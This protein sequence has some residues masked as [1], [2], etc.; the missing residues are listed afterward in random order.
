[1]QRHVGVLARVLGGAADLDLRERDLVDSLAADVLVGQRGAAEMAVGE[2]LERVRLVRFPDVALEHRVVRVAAHVDA[3]GGEDVAVV[4]GVVA[5]FRRGRVLEPGLQAGHDRLERELVGDAG[6]AVRDRD[7]ARL[8]RRDREREADQAGADRVERIGLDVERGE[9]GGGDPRDPGVERVERRHRLV[10]LD[11][12]L[13]RHGVARFERRRWR[14]RRRALA[15]GRT[16]APERSLELAPHRREAVAVVEGEQPVDVDLAQRERVELGPAEDVAREVAVGDDGDEPAPLRQPVD[17]L[18]QVLA[19]DALDL[20]RRRDHAFERAVLGD[21]LRRRLRADLLDAGN[22]VDRIADEGEVVDDPLGRNAELGGDALDVE[23]LVAH[24]VDERDVGVDELRQVLVAGRDDDLEAALGG[25]ARD[26]ADRV[27]GLDAGDGEDRPAE[28]LDRL[29]D[30]LDLLREVVGHRRPRRLVLGIP[31]VAEGLALV[32]ED[33]RAVRG[34]VLLAQQLHHRDDALDRSGR[35]AAGAAQVGKRV[36]GA[37]EVARAVDEQQGP[38]HHAAHCE[39]RG[40]TEPRA[41]ALESG[42]ENE[43]CR[44]RRR[45]CLAWLTART[46]RTLPRRRRCRARDSRRACR[47]RPPTASARRAGEPNVRVHGHRRW[48]CPH[49]GAARSRPA[50]EGHRRAERKRPRL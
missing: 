9:R 13:G 19:D 14:P 18:P 28:Q 1:M 34:R 48:P 23:P 6:V 40:T 41:G 20:R 27:V 7:V 50:A 22:V 38:I 11:D 46:R 12:R 21:P 49:R 25:H 29:D 42:H 4:L 15:R 35:D 33:A 17:R 2:A 47:H 26:R 45:R 31:V 24:R 32:V 37:V 5:D 44:R 16:G 36:I 10:V 43:R 3:E 8:A 39:G 30:R